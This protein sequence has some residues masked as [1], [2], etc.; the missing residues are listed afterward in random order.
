MTAEFFSEKNFLAA[1]SETRTGRYATI[2]LL[3]K[4]KSDCI[5]KTD[6]GISNEITR[7]GL[8][9]KEN[10]DRVLITKRK[11]VA[12]ERRKG[13]ELLRKLGLHHDCEINTENMC[14]NCID[15][16]IYGSAVG[17]GIS[18][19]SHVLTEET[20]SL[21]PFW[22]VITERTFNAIHETGTMIDKDGN[23]SQALG[24]DEV[25]RTGT[26]FLEMETIAD[27]TK[28]GFLYVLANILMTKRYGA[29]TSRLGKVDNAVVGIVLSNCELFSNLEWIQATYDAYCI[30][31]G[32]KEGENPQFPLDP[33]IVESLAKETAINLLEKIHGEV[34]PLST[35]QVGEIVDEITKIYGNEKLLKDFLQRLDSQLNP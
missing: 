1:R 34:A 27:V 19:K 35:E 18:R 12:P 33:I 24:K 15:C 26:F 21:L 20:F 7:A 17:K 10:I 6:T 30:K 29:M 28:E 3:R 4:T 23:Q 2:F 32:L 25:V 11:Q 22:D 5:F 8:V 16:Q 31:T 9:R 13:R 14:G